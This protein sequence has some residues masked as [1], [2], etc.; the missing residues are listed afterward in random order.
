MI[1]SAR[2]AL[3][4][5][6][7]GLLSG[8]ASLITGGPLI[9]PGEPVGAI[10]VI[11]RTSHPI[12]VVMISACSAA[13]YGMNRLPEGVSIPSG[14]SYQFQVE[15]LAACVQAAQQGFGHDRIADP[16]RRN[17]QASH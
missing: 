14:R 16:L 12:G 1:R 11:N 9:R 7:A 2:I 6:L 13:S 17:D 5:S 10:A 15:L 4:L 3:G 8:C